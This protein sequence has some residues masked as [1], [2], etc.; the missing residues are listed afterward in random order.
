MWRQPSPRNAGVAD[1]GPNRQ[2]APGVAMFRNG[3]VAAARRSLQEWKQRFAA[4]G[5]SCGIRK[6]DLRLVDALFELGCR[7]GFDAVSPVDFEA[8]HLQHINGLK[9]C[10]VHR[11]VLLLLLRF[12]NQMLIE[13]VIKNTTRLMACGA[14]VSKVGF[15]GCPLMC[16]ALRLGVCDAVVD[17]VARSLTDAQRATVFGR[18]VGCS[19]EFERFEALCPNTRLGQDA[20]RRAIIAD[21]DFV[22]FNWIGKVTERIPGPRRV[23]GTVLLE[24]L[25]KQHGWK[26]LCELLGVLFAQTWRV[27]NDAPFYL[28]VAKQRHYLMRAMA[29]GEPQDARLRSLAKD[30]AAGSAAALARGEPKSRGIVCSDSAAKRLGIAAR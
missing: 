16:E 9:V 6:S 13:A 23:V 21:T 15:P 19:S 28:D 10:T 14:A 22:D 24:E 8:A 27:A 20:L 3:D 25:F 18:L 4:P 1:T 29:G 5:R 17:V 26:R 30:L 2:V 12:D 11:D 7:D